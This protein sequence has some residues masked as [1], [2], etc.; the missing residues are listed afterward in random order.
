MKKYCRWKPTQNIVNFHILPV[1]T[2]VLAALAGAKEEA[3]FMARAKRAI[4]VFIFQILRM[5]YEK[6]IFDISIKW[7]SFVS[8]ISLCQIIGTNSFSISLCKFSISIFSSHLLFY[9][10]SELCFLWICTFEK[11]HFCTRNVETSYCSKA[12]RTARIDTL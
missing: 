8:W 3:D 1:V 7:F 4:E 12:T 5:Y 11:M 10:L 6:D 9:F 2:L